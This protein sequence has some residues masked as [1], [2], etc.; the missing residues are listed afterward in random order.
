[1]RVW[2]L[3]EAEGMTVD[4][5]SVQHAVLISE[6]IGDIGEGSSGAFHSEDAQEVGVHTL[7]VRIIVE[8]LQ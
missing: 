1:M 2:R 6:D 4:M 3:D 5:E 7:K 8:R